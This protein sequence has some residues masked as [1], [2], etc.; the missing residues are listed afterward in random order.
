MVLRG[1]G[2]SGTPSRRPSA[3]SAAILTY[4]TN[5]AVAVLS[6][7]S[8]LIV[9][10]VLGPSG[11]GNVA[12]LTAIGYLMPN[13]ATLGIQEA[14]VNIGGSTPSARR[15]LATNSIFFALIFGGGAALLLA[16]LVAVVP[17]IGGESSTALRALTFG[18]FPIL[19]FG[20]YMRFLAQADYGFRVTNAT[21]LMTATLN[22]AVNALLAAAGALSVGTAVLTWLA[23]QTISVVIVTWYVATRL[24]GFGRPDVALARRSLSFGTRSHIGRIMVLGNYRLD[25]WIVGAVSGSRQLGLYSVAVAWAEALWYL[26]TALAAV[27]RPDLVRADRR[28]AVRQTSH[29][30]RASMLITAALALVMAAAAPFLCVTIFGSEFEDSVLFLR[31]LL[32]GAFGIAAM[33]LFSNALTAQRH[34]G[35]SSLAVGAGFLC[36]V[37]LDIVLIPPYGGLGA[38]LASALA[39]SAGGVAVALLF[40]RVLGG[41][42]RDL[43][44]RVSDTTDILNRT[45]AVLRSVIDFAPASRLRSTTQAA[46]RWAAA[47]LRWIAIGGASALVVG[48]V[49]TASSKLAVGVAVV[50]AV[51]TAV[52]LRPANIL[53]VLI[54]VIFVE[55]IKIGGITIT[56]LIAPVALLVVLAAAIRPESALRFRAPLAWAIGYSVW[57]LASGLWTVSPSGTV[58]ALSSL[59]IALVFMLA[60]AT[61]LTTK[62][63]LVRTLWVLSIVSFVI[64]VF[65]IAAFIGRPM[66][67]FGLLQEGRVQGGTGDPSFFAATQLIAL[68]LILVLI[69]QTR[70][71]LPRLFLYVAAL[72][73]I[74]SVL[75]TV[76]RGGF[77]ELVAVGLIVILMPHNSLF[78]SRKHKMVAMVALLAGTTVF[79][80]HYQRDLLPR[81]QTIWVRNVDPS[82]SGRLNIWPA[83][84]GQFESHPV[85]GVG[86]GGWLDISVDQIFR[87]PEIELHGFHV[88]PEEAHNV[89]LGT[90][91]DLGLVGLFLFSGLLIAT[92]M[93]LRRTAARARQLGEVLIARVSSALLVGLLGWCVGSLFI[94][95]ETSRP[96]WIVIGLS[97]ALPK[98]LETSA[99]VETERAVVGAAAPARAR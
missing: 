75:S 93:A 46:D 82:A 69:T 99:E 74:A 6:L 50:I 28:E 71:L 61:M 68:P 2:E 40:L 51:A 64:A 80:V 47:P 13:L 42:A 63:E 9:S 70:S 15:S 1:Q 27:Q 35:L 76:S 55:L 62:R 65:S 20:I 53:P 84:L 72:V 24:A 18:S 23:G 66:L 54:A 90:A 10:R 22:V 39:Y 5:L 67:G 33:K 21:W 60:F 59:A 25:Q 88:H 7:V 91:T 4:G 30:F 57:A 87:S 48:E 97:L 52:I 36:T 85:A 38:S 95:T 56:R 96:L 32:L 31:V 17:A 11:R 73:N 26:P 19:V 94:E 98:L 43:V 78:R 79:F 3:S 16:G 45:R 77:V 58:T 49:A 44:P 37:I 89:F 14:N 83:A 8:V 81:L 92:A 12:F 86:Y 29:V 34:P 41:R